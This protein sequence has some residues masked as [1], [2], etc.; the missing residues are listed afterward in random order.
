MKRWFGRLARLI[1]LLL[2]LLLVGVSGFAAWQA[3]YG[4][5]A[6]LLDMA[7]EKLAAEGLSMNAERCRY[8]GKRG[9]VLDDLEL[10]STRGNRTP[11]FKGDLNV[12]LPI[13]SLLEGERLPETVRVAN[14]RVCYQ[15]LDW[16]ADATLHQPLVVDAV[17]GSVEVSSNRVVLESVRG[18]V[19]GIHLLLE[20]QLCTGA[21][22]RPASSNRSAV[23]QTIVEQLVRVVSELNAGTF[24]QPPLL[25][26]LVSQELADMAPD[27]EFGLEVLAPG[28][29][30][31]VAF[32]HGQC[33]GKYHEGVIL[34]DRLHFEDAVGNYLEFS[35]AFDPGV[36]EFYGALELSFPMP[37]LRELL[38]P[39]LV[40][41]LAAIG[42]VA[43]GR[44][45]G[46]VA[47]GPAR[48][49][50]A[51]RH[52]SGDLSVDRLRFKG[53]WFENAAMSASLLGSQL[54]VTNFTSVIG[55]QAGTGDT[56][57]H[58]R[59]N[60]NDGAFY[61][62]VKTNCDPRELIPMAPSLE[63][64]FRSLDYVDHPPDIDVV[65]S[66]TPGVIGSGTVEGL[67]RG[68]N[69][70]YNSTLIDYASMRIEHANKVTRL[71]DVYIERPEGDVS[72]EIDVDMNT[73][74]VRVD[75]NSTL[76]IDALARI[77]G[78]FAERVIRPLDFRGDHLLTLK[79]QF[80][81]TTNG[82]HQVVGSL[83]VENGG[84]S[85]WIFD[86]C[87][88]RWELRNDHFIISDAQ[89][90]LFDGPF[91]G[92]AQISDLRAKQAQQLFVHMVLNEANVSRLR[93]PNH[94]PQETKIDG[95]LTSR[96]ELESTLGRGFTDELTI[97][98][99][100]KLL[101]GRLFRIP[102][103]GGLS[104][105][106]SKLIPGF[107][108]STQTEFYAN[109][110][111]AER[112]VQFSEAELL[113]NVISATG[114]GTWN[115]DNTIN[116]RVG[117]KLLK[118]DNLFADVL[119]LITSPVTFLMDFKLHGSLEDPEWTLVHIPK[120]LKSLFK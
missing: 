36:D 45:S 53:T 114:Q 37:V 40:E 72:G 100:V 4:L 59:V 120:E 77:A 22:D 68:S 51:A 10:F 112:Q 74:I 5:P 103:F 86:D 116:A 3:R 1:L 115:F 23:V 15:Q 32:Q 83:Y 105:Y 82:R 8:L 25:T 95:L 80:D 38:P 21:S 65:I 54:E 67:I 48:L 46:Q 110:L 64:T 108:Y 90:R 73:R 85:W 75:L 113:G 79:G 119:R 24:T 117:V 102:V 47:I 9:W 19:G 97:R 31:G 60:L 93:L 41:Q 17:H 92:H 63:Q 94:D 71:R 118:A 58:I 56:D 6:V 2:V 13:L 62:R 39:T 111:V 42:V 49:K 33:L 11:F 16:D 76:D 61:I 50:D 43:P 35:G 26:L 99:Y 104:K 88:F 78:P 70:I 7:N 81:M 57:T 96:F 14:G 109:V 52:W 91:R 66:G 107:G 87:R 84:I 101:D 69:L 27:V 12:I 29:L 28:R 44:I 30:A 98:G 55:S 106:L 34:I 89:G 18:Q 20:G